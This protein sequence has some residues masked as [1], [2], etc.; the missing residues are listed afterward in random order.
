MA[1]TRSS[2]DGQ[3]DIAE[4]H[5][6]VR[7]WLEKIYCDDAIPQYEIN[8]RTLGILLELKCKNE[9]RESEAQIL[10]K[11]Y[12]EKTEEYHAEGERLSRILQTV[13]LS[14]SN[15]SQSGN[16]SLRSLAKSALTLGIKDASVSSFYQAVTKLSTDSLD[17]EEER[18]HDQKTISQLFERT[19]ATLI[20][21]E[22]L[23]RTLEQVEEE[24]KAIPPEM[25]KKIRQSGFLQNKAKEYSKQMHQLKVDLEKNGVN[26]SIY[27]QN[28]V[29]LAEDLDTLQK[30]IAPLKSKLD[31]YHNLPPTFHLQE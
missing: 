14:T 9:E 2:A 19:K 21:V 3:Q 15:L 26:P 23:K 8:E 1:M 28:L 22:T 11:D 20:K 17:V 13:G 30:K 7:D 31:S 29:K 4:K 10:I 24:A 12:Q 5:K 18:M 27:H 16:V 6:E 25:D